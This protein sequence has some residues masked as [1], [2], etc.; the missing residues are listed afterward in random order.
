MGQMGESSSASQ[1]G[2][3]LANI[4]DQ[5]ASDV[6]ESENDDSFS[7]TFRP[8]LDSNS[9][10]NLSVF[11]NG[12]VG[13]GIKFI[14]KITGTNAQG[15]KDLF[16]GSVSDSIIAQAYGN[17]GAIRITIKG[18]DLN[19]YTEFNV[20]LIITNDTSLTHT[21]TICSYTKDDNGNVCVK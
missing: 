7:V 11:G 17:N 16:V 5:F 15:T 12:A 18:A 14:I 3:F 21:K 20:Q 10:L 2:Y 19:E 8:S 13:N 6:V 1:T 9:D 4:T